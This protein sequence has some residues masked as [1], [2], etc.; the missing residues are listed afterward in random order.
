MLSVQTLNS[1]ISRLPDGT[2]EN[3][4]NSS[5]KSGKERLVSRS[6][7]CFFLALNRLLIISRKLSNSHR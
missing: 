3:V 1:F 5:M 4:E 7:A 6:K 2:K